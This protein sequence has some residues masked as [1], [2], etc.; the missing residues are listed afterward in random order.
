MKLLS[1]LCTT[2]LLSIVSLSASNLALSQS[3]DFTC[4]SL[5]LHNLDQYNAECQQIAPN[6][7]SN[8]QNSSTSKVR[9]FNI[10]RQGFLVVNGGAEGTYDVTSMQVFEDGVKANLAQGSVS[11]V[12]KFGSE[13]NGNWQMA[14][15]GVMLEVNGE[16]QNYAHITSGMCIVE[17]LMNRS[18]SGAFLGFGSFD[19]HRGKVQSIYATKSIECNAQDAD[20]N[21]IALQGLQIE[22]RYN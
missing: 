14:L 11:F 20:G 1:V 17:N 9:D 21:S 18:P 6:I 8:T 13:Q 2:T 16:V 22:I 3:S 10:E 4:E 5:R 15:Q 19:V 7:T 12:S